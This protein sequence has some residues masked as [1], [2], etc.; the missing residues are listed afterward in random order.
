MLI[1]AKGRQGNLRVLGVQTCAGN[2]STRADWLARQWAP[3]RAASFTIQSLRHTDY[4][5]YPAE[6]ETGYA[7]I[8]VAYF[9]TKK[10]GETIL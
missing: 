3:S 8:K 6:V 4:H 1:N 9:T 5:G 2:V 7:T 10:E